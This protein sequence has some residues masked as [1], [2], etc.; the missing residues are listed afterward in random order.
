[1][2][3]SPIQEE[4]N[5]ISFTIISNGKVIPDTYEIVSIKVDQKVNKIAE[6]EIQILDGNASKQ[7]F[8]ITESDWFEP[9]AEIEIEMGYH[10]KNETV[11]KGLVIKQAIKIGSERDSMLQVICNDKALKMAI[12]RKNAIF[13]NDT[14]SSIIKK[15][16]GNNGL[17]NNVSSTTIEHKEVVQYDATDWDFIITRAEMNGMVVLTENGKLVV[18]KPSVSGSPELEVQYGYDILDFDGEID[19]TFQ[20][21][22]AESNAWDMSSQTVI[23]SIATDPKVNTQGDLNGK[24]LS[25]VLAAGTH[26]LNSSTYLSKEEI[27]SWADAALLKSRLSRFKGSVVFQG[28]AKAK[29]NSIIKLGGLGKRFNG[30]AYISGVIHTIEEGQWQTEVQLGLSAEWF[31]E[32]RPVSAK[33]ASGLLPAVTG[34]QTGI[35]KKIYEDPDNQFRV[36]VELPL[37]KTQGDGIWARLSTFYASKGFG[38]FFMPEIGDEVILGFMNDDPRFPVI[39][40]SVY[41]S[42]RQAAEIPDEQ[43]TFKSIVTRS[44]MQFKFDDEN[45]IITVLTPNGNSMVISDK[46]KQITIQDENS[47]SIIMSES[48]IVMKSPKDIV[49]EADQ[50]VTIKGTQG[51]TVESSAGDVNTSAMNIKESADVEFSAEGSASASVQ[52]GGELTLKGAMVM[53]N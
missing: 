15:I 18:S 16:V 19:A 30:N 21:G 3:V 38:A 28:S 52:G 41:S 7:T 6:A 25:E 53:I 14:D 44:K 32:T 26:P 23:N 45:K 46:D 33:E 17:K 11:F 27:K 8:E 36:H 4:T 12:N 24:I 29:P 35:V 22:G 31:S 50:T 13:T 20:Y 47:N 39:L 1:M 9:G 40:G 5:L 43:N 49:L 10:G 48:G 37:L 34:L 42:S 51:I 2:S